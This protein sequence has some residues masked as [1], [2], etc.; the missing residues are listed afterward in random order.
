MS[1]D[2]RAFHEMDPA[3]IVRPGRDKVVFRRDV[4]PEKVGS[5]VVPDTSRYRDRAAE[6]TVIAVG[7]DVTEFKA[8]DR[9]L[10]PDLLEARGKFSWRGETY[11]IATMEQLEGV[12]VIG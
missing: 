11:T 8:G 9:L 2:I 12:A 7:S 5:I 6:A 4:N 1:N 10:L 3:R